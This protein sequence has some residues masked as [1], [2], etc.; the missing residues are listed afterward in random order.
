MKS[1]KQTTVCIIA[2]VS[3]MLCGCDDNTPTNPGEDSLGTV[4]ELE[5]KLRNDLDAP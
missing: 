2:L 5:Q 4:E 1:S 3:L